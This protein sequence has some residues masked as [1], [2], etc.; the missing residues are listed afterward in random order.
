MTRKDYRLLAAVLKTDA[1]HLG[2]PGFNYEAANDWQRGAY[3]QWCTT[4][5]AIAYA[6]K[7]DNPSFSVDR[8]MRA[9]KGE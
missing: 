7:Q 5:L 9:C 8:F 3:D 2:K 6:L 4:M 1:A